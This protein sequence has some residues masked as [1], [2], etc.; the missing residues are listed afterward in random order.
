MPKEY[1]LVVQERDD[2]GSILVC[3]YNLRRGIYRIGRGHI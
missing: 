2:L 1:V 3:F